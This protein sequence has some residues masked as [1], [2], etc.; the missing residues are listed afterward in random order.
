MSDE[1]EEKEVDIHEAVSALK[2]GTTEMVEDS[3]QEFPPEEVEARSDGWVPEDEWKGDPNK[4]VPAGEFVRRKSLFEKIHNQNRELKKIKEQLQ[5]LKGHH[6]K[7]YESSYQQALQDLQAQRIEAIREGDAE[8]VV[9]IEQ[10][11]DQMKQERAQREPKQAGPSESFVEWVKDNNWYNENPRMRH[12]ADQ[13]GWDYKSANPDL[14]DEE[15]FD[16]VRERMEIEYPKAFQGRSRP[17]AP[18]V[19]GGSATHNETTQNRNSSRSVTL[20]DEEKQVM[21]TL[22]RGG[23]MTKEEYMQEVAKLN[24][25]KS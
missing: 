17:T 9:N 11:I 13:V 18:A 10:S 14:P 24:K 20:T 25:R 5:A 2:E 12:R 4:W 23:V 19:D 6:D 16:Y 15:I 21:N 22:V 1:N 8:T 7:V 3:A